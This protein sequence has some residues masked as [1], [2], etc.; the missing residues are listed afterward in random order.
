MSIFKLSK[1]NHKNVLFW[2][3]L[4]LLSIIFVRSLHVVCEYGSF[5]SIPTAIWYSSSTLF[6]NIRIVQEIHE[7]QHSNTKYSLF[8]FSIFRAASV[9]YGTFQASG[10][11]GATAAGLSYSHSNPDLSCICDLHHSSWQCQILNPPSK[12]RGVKPASSWRF[13]GL[14][15]NQSYS[16]RPTP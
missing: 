16:C 11:I 1:W 14:G 10:R 4:I 5:I 13:P 12:A 9:T 3:W 7:S 6:Q 2:V 8:F 15:S